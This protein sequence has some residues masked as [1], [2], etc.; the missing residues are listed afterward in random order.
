MARSPRPHERQSAER[1]ILK[2][3]HT[4]TV[5]RAA[6]GRGRHRRTPTRRRA[7][8]QSARYAAATKC[9]N[10]RM[11]AVHVAPIKEDCILARRLIWPRTDRGG[12]LRPLASLK[13]TADNTGS[14]PPSWAAVQLCSN[15]APHRRRDSCRRWTSLG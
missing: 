14:S 4:T 7:A 15:A 2:P 12:R 8:Q 5:V 1:R 13:P 3:R 6:I 10:Q 9:A 11:A